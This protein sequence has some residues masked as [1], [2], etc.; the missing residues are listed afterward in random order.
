MTAFHQTSISAKLA[1][2]AFLALVLVFCAC[3]SLSDSACSL[4]LLDQGA[5]YCVDGY[6]NS[7]HPIGST[8]TNKRC[9]GC[10]CS[11]E[12]MKCCDVV[13]RAINLS[14]GCI[15]KYDYN[16]KCTFEVFN[17]TNPNMICSYDVVGKEFQ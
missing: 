3:V 13:G 9:I 5:E 14:Q 16:N 11:P 7:K 17:P 12:E 4:T 1:K 8:W 6:D 10:T 2:M 15:A